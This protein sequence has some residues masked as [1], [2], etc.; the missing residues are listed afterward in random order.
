MTKIYV[1]EWVW[2]DELKQLRI[3]NVAKVKVKRD[4][5]KNIAYIN[6]KN[7]VIPV[8]LEDL[9]GNVF[10]VINVSSSIL[11]FRTEGTKIKNIEELK[12]HAENGGKFA[13]IK[14]AEI[15]IKDIDTKGRK[16]DIDKL[17]PQAVFERLIVP[18]DM[19]PFFIYQFKRLRSKYGGF[20]EKYGTVL[21]LVLFMVFSLAMAYV[22]ADIFGGTCKAIS[23]NFRQGMSMFGDKLANILA[24]ILAQ[25]GVQGA[26]NVPAPITPP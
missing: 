25:Q 20:W 17:P 9:D 23:E 19:R 4:I 16:I 13:P 21:T 22:M 14:G 5:S 15:K 26:Q 11:P 10:N 7:E 1:V 8:R 18:V 6:Y 12:K 2:N 24:Q 3:R